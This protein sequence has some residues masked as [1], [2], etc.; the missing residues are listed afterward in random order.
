MGRVK[1]TLD[2]DLD[3]SAFQPDPEIELG[4]IFRVLSHRIEE[5]HEKSGKI[6]DFNGATVGRFKIT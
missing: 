1:L 6:R 2:I 5:S 3:N 4:R